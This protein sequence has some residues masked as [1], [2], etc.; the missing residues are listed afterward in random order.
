LIHRK[1]NGRVSQTFAKGNNY[2]RSLTLL[3]KVDF[4]QSAYLL[5]IYSQGFAT[6]DVDDDAW[7]VRHFFR[8]RTMEMCIAQSFSKNF[9]LYGE[10]VGAFH[11]ITNSPQAA[12]KSRTRLMILQG[13]EISTPPAYGAKIV[14]AVLGDDDLR[15]EWKADLITMTSRLKGMRHALYDELTKLR[16]PGDWEHLKS[17]VR[18]N[19]IP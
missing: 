13:G 7:A 9:G 1:L 19:Q 2:S 10:R 6:G 15:K 12:V 14:A 16:T 17:Q 4:K 5:T 3:S 8:R 11:L 18:P